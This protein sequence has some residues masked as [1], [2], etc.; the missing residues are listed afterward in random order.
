[1]AELASDLPLLYVYSFL[2]I[3]RKLSKHQ[4]LVKPYCK[5][6][7]CHEATSLM[8]ICLSLDEPL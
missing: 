3:L 6:M 2:D 7:W 4:A 8:C 1:M 5:V